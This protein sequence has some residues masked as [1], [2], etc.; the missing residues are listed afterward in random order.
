[1][2]KLLQYINVISS[3]NNNNNNIIISVINNNTNNNNNNIHCFN[4]FH[5]KT[6][7][8]SNRMKNEK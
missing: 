7:D 4:C 8:N 1:M 5:V 2:K 6:E 3:N